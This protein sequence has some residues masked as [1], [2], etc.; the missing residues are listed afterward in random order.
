MNKLLAILNDIRVLQGVVLLNL[1]FSFGATWNA[2]NQY[3][4]SSTE[5]LTGPEADRLP[6]TKD[7]DFRSMASAFQQFNV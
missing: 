7:C 1:V 2:D 5:N 4:D 3:A 6:Y